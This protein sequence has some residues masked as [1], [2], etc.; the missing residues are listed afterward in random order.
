MT[1]WRINI[2]LISLVLSFDC[3]AQGNFWFANDTTGKLLVPG[4]SLVSDSTRVEFE[5]AT[6]AGSPISTAVN[7]NFS[8]DTAKYNFNTSS[9]Y[10][11]FIA[12]HDADSI[13]AGI[14][15]VSPYTQTILHK[16]GNGV[17]TIAMVVQ[18]TGDVTDVFRATVYGLDIRSGD[19]LEFRNNNGQPRMDYVEFYNNYTPG[20]GVVQE[21]P[22]CN[23]GIRNGD[24]TDID[25]GGSCPPCDGGVT[26]TCFDGIQNQDETGVD[27]GGAIC[28]PCSIA[29]ASYEFTIPE[30]EDYDYNIGL[31]P[32][33]V[34]GLA[35]S[36]LTWKDTLDN[37]YVW[38]DGDT[39]K[40]KYSFDFENGNEKNTYNLLFTTS[41]GNAYGTVTVTNVSGKFDTDGF[42]DADIAAKYPEVNVGDYIYWG[43]NANNDQNLNSDAISDNI[44][45][46]SYPNKILIKGGDYGWIRLYYYGVSGT[47]TKKPIVITNFLGQVVTHDGFSLKEDARYIRLTGQYDQ[48]NGYGHRYFV[49]CDKN[50]ST[51]DYSYA[52]GTFGIMADDKWESQR[53]GH[54]YAVDGGNFYGI[55]V[56][57][58]EGHSGFFSGLNRKWNN[59]YALTDSNA[60]HH[61]YFHDIGSEGVYQGST[62]QS[63]P[64]QLFKNHEVYN[65]VCVRIGGEGIQTGR[66]MNHSKVY[67]NISWAGLDWKDP[68]Q[69]Y[70]DGNFQTGTNGGRVDVYNNIIIGYGESGTYASIQP[71]PTFASVTHPIDTFSFYNNYYGWGR[72]AL[73]WFTPSKHDGKT[74]VVIRDNYFGRQGWNIGEV[75]NYFTF[76]TT[77]LYVIDVNLT[78]TD[79]FVNQAYDNFFDSTSTAFSRDNQ[80]TLSGNEQIDVATPKFIKSLDT[81]YTTTDTL[82][83]DQ[84]DSLYFKFDRYCNII[85]THGTFIRSDTE[86]PG[87]ISRKGEAAWWEVGDIVQYWNSDGE[88]RFYY[89]IQA[90]STTTDHKPSQSDYKPDNSYWQMITWRKPDGTVTPYPPD[91][92]RLQNGTYK[93][94][95][96]GLKEN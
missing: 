65:N 80:E 77:S 12:P 86:I 21:T 37:G 96:M 14:G 93:T 67:N 15:P 91:D 11:Q 34:T 60:A 83:F 78:P 40:S 42:A 30:N 17:D 50:S 18:T 64:Q 53:T 25:C 8:N 45:G 72:G 66:L 75:Y 38:L 95:G 3:L 41:N 55:E 49:G 88:T 10:A 13:I 24:E 46:I 2:V 56:D 87:G 43:P 68:F 20:Q 51:I 52:W 71:E 16:D 7:S 62:T 29:S 26:E 23:D 92:F 69:R 22:D 79:D 39:L 57:H 90:D 58:I 89:C 5:D 47:N 31:V 82:V 94:L 73:T 19:T 35:T 1:L 70:Q 74:S 9:K 33:S 32:D 61:I 81:G 84:I 44:T 36:S 4:I 59:N 63:K 76:G 48:T 28:P 54:A 85:G 6:L 27:C